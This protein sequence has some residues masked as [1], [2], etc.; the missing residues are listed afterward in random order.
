MADGLPIEGKEAK[1]QRAGDLAR[2]DVPICRLNELLGDVEQRVHKTGWDSCVVANEG[3]IV[4]GLLGPK[5]LQ[6]DPQMTAEQAMENGPRTY[7]LDAPLDKVREHFQKADTDRVLVTTSD[8][9]LFGLLRR[10]DV[11]KALSAG[12]PPAA[13]S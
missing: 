1:T 2:Q 13:R 4:L 8:G 3:R 11:E 5:A 7:R 12:M 9:K 10:E 6:A